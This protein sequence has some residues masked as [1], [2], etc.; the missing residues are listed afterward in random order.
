MQ[1]TAIFGVFLLLASLP[2]RET[3]AWGLAVLL[4]AVLLWSRAP[5]LALPRRLVHLVAFPGLLW[6]VALHGVYNHPLSDFG[7]DAWYF[8]LP[9]VYLALGYLMFERIRRWQYLLQPFLVVGV[10]LSCYSLVHAALN[11]GELATAATVDAYRAVTGTGTFL[12]IVPLVL[13]LLV[14]R[15]HLAAAGLERFRIFRVF[16]YAVCTLTVLVSLSRTHIITLVAGLLCAVSPRTLLRRLLRSGGLGLV[17]AMAVLLAG[18]GYLATA[19]TGQSG[20]LQLFAAKVLNSTSEVQVRAYETYADI[21]NNWRGYEA[22][23]AS[24]TFAAFSLP[25]QIFGGGDGTLVDL[26]LF[27]QLS[28]TEVFMFV[29]ILHNGYMYLL[30][31]TGVLGLGLFFLFILQLFDYGRRALRLP[32]LEAR[33]AGLVLL[34]T[35]LVMLATQGVITGIYNK[36]ELIPALFLTGAALAGYTERRAM[37]ENQVP[38]LVRK[39]ATPF[40]LPALAPQPGH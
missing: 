15:E 3:L 10:A 9:V 31:K 38:A 33:V 26:G 8:T 4:C 39:P 7:K 14:R 20:P 32:D 21:N 13:L 6:C 1:W 36:G 16:T 25:E 2:G 23:R 29:P 28:A 30:V 34:W 24:K 27:M 22:Y 11:R 35:P 18:V 40:A 5:E 12:S 37:L 19:K 17:A